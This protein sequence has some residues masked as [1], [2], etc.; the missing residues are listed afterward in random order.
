[1]AT[2]KANNLGVDRDEVYKMINY[3][4]HLFHINL[5]KRVPDRGTITKIQLDNVIKETREDLKGIYE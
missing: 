1:M 2:Q 3:A 4:F 5:L